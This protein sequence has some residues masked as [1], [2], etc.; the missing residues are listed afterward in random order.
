MRLYATGQNYVMWFIF[1][2][3]IYGYTVY[4]PPS[5]PIKESAV[6]LTGCKKASAHLRLRQ[7]RVSSRSTPCNFTPSISHST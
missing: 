1:A 7:H 6:V 2:E 5:V 3:R 4:Q